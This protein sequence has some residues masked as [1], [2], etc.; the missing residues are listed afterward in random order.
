MDRIKEYALKEYPGRFRGKEHL[1]EIIEEENFY[2]VFCKDTSP[3]FLS[4]NT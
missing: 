3:V 1:I 2:K 4:K